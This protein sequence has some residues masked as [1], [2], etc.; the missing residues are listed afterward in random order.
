MWKGTTVEKSI[1]TGCGVKVLETGSIECECGVRVMVELMAL[2]QPEKLF[3]C[4][5]MMQ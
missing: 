5:A 1:A 3:R 2:I 4:M